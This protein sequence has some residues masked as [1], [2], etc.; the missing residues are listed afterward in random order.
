[1]AINYYVTASSSMAWKVMD[2]K[3]GI[4][5]NNNVTESSR[6]DLASQLAGVNFAS[7]KIGSTYDLSKPTTPT[8]PI[9]TFNVTTKTSP[10]DTFQASYQSEAGKSS[11]G[12]DISSSMYFLTTGFSNWDGYA[13]YN[14]PEVSLLVSK[15]V[16]VQDEPT[17]N[18][19]PQPTPDTSKDSKTKPSTE[20]TT[21]P[22]TTPPDQPPT[23]PPKEPPVTPP[24]TGGEFPLAFLLVGGA[25]AAAVVVAGI[26][27]KTKRKK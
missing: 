8:D 23:E 22:P 2:E 10:I 25:V 1:M 16:D 18:P 11:T 5:S 7:V 20:P 19:N 13:V 12:F 15:G 4:V 9:R 6:F 24:T 3:G 21:E 26:A 27:V 14:D 17:P